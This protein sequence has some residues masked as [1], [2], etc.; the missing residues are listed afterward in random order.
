VLP[1]VGKRAIAGAAIFVAAAATGLAELLR[2]RKRR[3]SL[4][5]SQHKTTGD[6]RARSLA[7]KLGQDPEYERWTAAV[8]E[9][10]TQGIPEEQMIGKS[11]LLR[12]KQALR[13]PRS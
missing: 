13:P 9:E 6:E 12:R 3:G 1:T 4:V 7:T 11:E 2:Y 10:V 5:T 8:R